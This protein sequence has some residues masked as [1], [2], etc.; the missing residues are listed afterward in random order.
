MAAANYSETA[1]AIS[2]NDG[3]ISEFGYNPQTGR[4]EVETA[5]GREIYM[6]PAEIGVYGEEVLT[7]EDTELEE[8]REMMESIEELYSEAEAQDT[9]GKLTG[10]ELEP[11]D[12]SV[13]MK[14]GDFDYPTERKAKLN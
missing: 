4:V 12:E 7:E 11:Q 2:E 8:V 13:T 9:V 10:N 6:S 3:G 1:R 14:D 5:E